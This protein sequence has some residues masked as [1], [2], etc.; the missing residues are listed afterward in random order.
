MQFRR[1]WHS[2]VRRR[3]LDAE[4]ADEMRFHVE[5]QA[6]RLIRE[7]GLEPVEARRQALVAFG[8]V[9]KYRVEGRDA[10]GAL[11]LSAAG[12]DAPELHSLLAVVAALMLAVGAVAAAV[13]ARRIIRLPVTDALRDDA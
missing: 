5:M 7:R 1:A 9:E 3:R 11:M 2:L 8:G 10:R 4:S 6:E 12:F 13:P